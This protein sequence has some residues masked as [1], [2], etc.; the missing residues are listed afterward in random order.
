MRYLFFI[1]ICCFILVNTATAQEKEDATFK[2][3]VKV[4]GLIFGDF[5]YRPHSDSLLRGTTQYAGISY[6]DPKNFSS[7]DIRRIYLGGDFI[8]TNKISGELLLANEGN[9]DNQ[10]NATFSIKTANICWNNIYKNANLIIGRAMTPAFPL[11]TEKVWGYRSIERTIADMRN[12]A[13]AVDLGVSLQAKLNDSGTA[14][15]NLMIGNGSV[16]TPPN[17]QKAENDMFKKFYG[18]IWAKLFDK[19]LVLDFYADYE[20]D[21]L[22]DLATGRPFPK[23]K[24]TF[25]GFIAYQSRK[26]T[27]GVEAFMQTQQNFSIYTQT[28]STKADTANAY[29][30]GISGYIYGPIWKKKL[31]FFARYDI[32]NP[33]TKYN[34]AYTYQTGNVNYSETFMTAGLDWMPFKNFHLMPNVWIDSYKDRQM[35]NGVAKNDYDM[36]V[37]MT[38]YYVY[39]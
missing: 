12:I 27:I 39:K 6:P 1:L 19:K 25:K 18:D 38:F 13:S 2:P 35:I 37:R 29:S 7:F 3:S 33:D 36:S 17:G 26:V 10:K 24:Y 21:Q 9:T 16:G 14:G 22:T 20:R 32:Y 8:F 30:V 34:A 31:G 23:S 4:W 11:L 5:E 28:G 15:Y